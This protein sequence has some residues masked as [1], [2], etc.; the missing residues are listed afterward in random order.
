LTI[1]FTILKVFAALRVLPTMFYPPV[2]EIQVKQAIF[3]IFV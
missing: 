3:C 2:P 1:K